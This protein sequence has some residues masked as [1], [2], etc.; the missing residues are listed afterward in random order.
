MLLDEFTCKNV[1]R[2]W[3]MVLNSFHLSSSQNGV[4]KMPISEM[5]RTY[6]TVHFWLYIYT[7]SH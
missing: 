2:F 7:D 6:Q 3:N 4:Y 5:I 1:L